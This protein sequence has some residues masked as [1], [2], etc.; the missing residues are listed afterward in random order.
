MSLLYNTAMVGD[1]IETDIRPA[2][3]A[4]VNAIWLRSNNSHE[5]IKNI[6]TIDNLNELILD[7]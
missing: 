2:L 5:S 1:N 6:Q 4:G 7:S 3:S